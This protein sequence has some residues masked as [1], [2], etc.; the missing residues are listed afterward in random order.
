MMRIEGAVKRTEEDFSTIFGPDSW[1]CSFY[2][3][4][5]FLWEELD[6]IDEESCGLELVINI[7]FNIHRPR[8]RPLRFFPGNYYKSNLRA[9]V[10][11]NS[12]SC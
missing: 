11:G 10:F 9:G 1:V 5:S 8:S 2:K 3:S 4:V 12:E 6:R 7:C